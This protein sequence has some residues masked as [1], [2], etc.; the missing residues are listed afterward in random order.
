VEGQD[1]ILVSEMTLTVSL[2]GLA[3]VT[4][5]TTACRP[6]ITVFEPDLDHRSLG[7]FAVP[8]AKFEKA[9]RQA[10][11]SHVYLGVTGF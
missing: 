8:L 11:S 2:R 5:W 6:S 9:R 10:A 3:A 4:V 1:P 7:T